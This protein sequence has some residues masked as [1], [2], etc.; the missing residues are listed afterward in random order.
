MT[1][2]L[3]T[4]DDAEWIRMI[5]TEHWGGTM[6]TSLDSWYDASQEH[7][8]IAEDEHRCGLITFRAES[9]ALEVLTLNSFFEDRGIGSQLLRA[10]EEL[11]QRWAKKR[12]YLV[13]TNDNMRALGFYQRRGYVLSGVNIGALERARVLKPY[14]PEI[15]LDG[16][17]LRDELVLTK[18]LPLE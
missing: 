8:L 9:Y 16:I 11:G 15:G 5:L 10:V 14:I 18:F 17:P 13:T 4:E 6:I 12:V 7:A 2:R 1:I 3:A